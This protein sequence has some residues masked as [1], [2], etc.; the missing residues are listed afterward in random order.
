MSKYLKVTISLATSM[1]EDQV[2]MIKFFAIGSFEIDDFIKETPR[3]LEINQN[4]R[5]GFVDNESKTWK[6]KKWQPRGRHYIQT[7][8]ITDIHS[9]V[10]ES[11]EAK[12]G[13]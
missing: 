4:G 13:E 11:V 5:E 10:V 1:A 6:L 9:E 12:D 3:W 8:Q 7:S 2:Y